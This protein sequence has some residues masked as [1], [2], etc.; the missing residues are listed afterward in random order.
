VLARK[1]CR[2]CDARPQMRTN[3]PFWGTSQLL[4][5]ADKTDIPRGVR[6]PSPKTGIPESG[7]LPALAQP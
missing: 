3:F 2:K 1:I 6:V 7:I 5:A 4:A